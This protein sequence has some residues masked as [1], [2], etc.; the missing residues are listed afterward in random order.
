M[1]GSLH[2][3]V[4]AVGLI[5]LAQNA[6]VVAAARPGIAAGG[7]RQTSVA[8]HIGR[9]GCPSAVAEAVAGGVAI[10]VGGAAVAEVQA[11]VGVAIAGAHLHVATEALVAACPRLRILRIHELA[12]AG[13]PAL[14]GRQTMR[15]LIRGHGR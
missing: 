13:R 15:V 11:A 8:A 14:Q 12:E 9:R 5:T 6:A 1:P 2:C 7:Q 10:A 4:P 3:R